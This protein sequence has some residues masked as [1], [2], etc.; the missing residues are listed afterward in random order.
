MNGNY[1]NILSS[2]LSFI[3]IENKIFFFWEHKGITFFE[4]LQSICKKKEY[5][6]SCQKTNK[7]IKVHDGKRI[8]CK[9]RKKNT[10]RKGIWYSCS[11]LNT[12]NVY[13]VVC[14]VISCSSSIK[15]KTKSIFISSFSFFCSVKL[16]SKKSPT[17]I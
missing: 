6:N 3:K 10:R 9:I 7:K 14:L 2:T 4:Q 11:L 16:S 1:P 5:K 17:K 8:S 13:T 12:W 15:R